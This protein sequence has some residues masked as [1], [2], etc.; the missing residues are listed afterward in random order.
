MNRQASTGVGLDGRLDRPHA[1]AASWNAWLDH[2]LIAEH[3]RRRALVDDMPWERWVSARLGR[4]PAKS[5]Q[6]GCGAADRS[7]FLYE[8]GLSRWIDGIDDREAEIARAEEG[9]RTAGAPGV[10]RVAD[11]NAASLARGTYDLIFSC[12]SF[13]RFVALEHVLDQ[14]HAALTPGGYFVLEEFVGPSR[15]QWTDAQIAVVRALL[16][17]VPQRLRT[18]RWGLVKPY[19]GRPS[20]ADVA[21]AAPFESIRS[22]E[23]VPLVSKRFDLVVVRPLGGTLQHLLYNGIVH[24]FSPEDEEATRWIEGIGR[25]EDALVDSGCLPSDFLLTIGRRRQAFAPADA[26]R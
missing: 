19:E 26:G 9:R 24:N 16:S 13:R 8:A 7:L 5:L 2:P 21:A 20:R 23:I 22:A 15:F 1:G 25:V 14:V 4:P 17:L 18:F 12:H 11:V 6:L 10:F 3:Y